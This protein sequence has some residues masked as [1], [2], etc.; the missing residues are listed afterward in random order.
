MNWTL[1][2]KGVDYLVMSM[3]R[4]F[5][6]VFRRGCLLWP[7]HSLGKTLLAFAL[8][9][10]VLQGQICLLLQVSFDFLLLHSSPLW[11][12]GHPFWVLVLEGLVGPHW[13][14]Q[15]QLLQHTGWGIDFDYCDIQWF[16][17]ETKRSFCRFWGY[18]QVLY[19]GIFC[20]L[21]GIHHLLRDSFPQ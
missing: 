1:W 16:A 4:A 5:S 11:W 14:V 13:T 15:F 9:H 17:L 18:T 3:C 20:W 19:F 21:W 2:K 10:F 7:V 8:L 12:K 6:C